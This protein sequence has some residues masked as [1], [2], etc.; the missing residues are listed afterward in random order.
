[1]HKI[2]AGETTFHSFVGACHCVCMF[3]YLFNRC[4]TRSKHIAVMVTQM[5][6]RSDCTAFSAAVSPPL[7]FFSSS[8]ELKLAS[9][10]S[11]H[12]DE[13]LIFT[14]RYYTNSFLHP[15]VDRGLLGE[16]P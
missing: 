11:Q 12:L 9:Q 15:V 13:V 5:S 10:Q 16:K 6:Q 7:S 14:N 4:G 3:V 2:K 1:M 8:E